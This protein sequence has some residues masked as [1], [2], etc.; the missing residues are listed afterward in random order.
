MI[1]KNNEQTII[2]SRGLTDIIKFFAAIMVAFGHYASHAINF[3]TS[4]AYRVTVMFAGNVGVALFFF[5]SGYG[6]MMSERKSHLALWPFIKRRISKVYLP[7]ILVSFVWQLILWPSGAGWERLPHLLY[8][9]FWGFS[10]GILWFVKAI[11]ICYALFRIYL[12]FNKVNRGRVQVT[13][14][15][16]GTAVVYAVVYILFEGWAAISIPLFSLGIL[17]ADY[18]KIC[19]RIVRSW[20]LVMVVLGVTIIMVGLYLWKG[21]LYLHSLTDWY[22]IMVLLIVCA[23][24]HIEIKVPSWMGSISYDVYITHNKVINY[25]KP[26]YSNIGLLHFLIGAI[27]AAA[28]SYSIRKL[29]RI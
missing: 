29:L 1:R 8:A 13:L 4:P 22:V 16:I 6:L 14:L 11:L 20:W 28:A 10:D 18:N 9:T 26:I 3:S 12:A 21:N 19:W 23:I 15:L 25:L 17:V 5:L 7:V 2:L 27:I 24:F